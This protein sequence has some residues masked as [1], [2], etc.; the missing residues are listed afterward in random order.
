MTAQT[1][2][3]ACLEYIGEF[4]LTLTENTGTVTTGTGVFRAILRAINEAQQELYAQN[5]RLFKR[6]VGLSVKAAQS[7]TVAVTNNSTAVTA[8]SFTDTLAGQTILIAGQAEYNAL[9]TECAS[10]KLA[11]PYTGSTGTQAATLYGDVLPLDV[12]FARPLGPVW[13]SDIRILNPLAGKAAL[14]GYD[15]RQDLDCNW[16]FYPFGTARS[17]APRTIGQP[18]A[19]YI[20]THVPEAGGP[21]QLRIFLTPIPDRAYSL[22]F[23]AEVSPTAILPAD[24]GTEGTD[25]GKTFALPGG[26]EERFLLPLVLYFWSRS[27][28]FKN[29]E[30]RKQIAQDRAAILP[31]IEAWKAQPQTG[32]HLAVGGWR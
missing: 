11:F 4:S 27:A 10:K 32:S 12:A 19:Y 22:R 17:V 30:A 7:G 23:D 16:G 5:P 29:A 21:P 13:L 18:E 8:T 26:L 15:P 31:A 24:L 6:E 9:R 28:W 20:G 14:L 25:P 1:L 3:Y 2:A